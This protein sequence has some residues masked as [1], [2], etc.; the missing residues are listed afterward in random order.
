MELSGKGGGLYYSTVY[1][2]HIIRGEVE[3]TDPIIC[4]G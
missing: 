2:V 4:S 1:T 3:K